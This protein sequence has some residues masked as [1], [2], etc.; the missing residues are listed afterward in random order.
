MIRDFI[1][2][3][4]ILFIV[5]GLCCFS[6]RPNG[7]SQ[8]LSDQLH[9]E[10]RE[11]YGFILS[12]HKH[13]RYIAEGHFFM[14]ELSAFKETDGQHDWE[15]IYNFPDIGFSF[16]ATNL[17]HSTYIGNA[18]GLFPFLN[19]P[20]TKKNNFSQSLRVGF[21][22]G[23]IEKP[24]DV[25]TNY[26]NIML[27]SRIN[28]CTN[29]LYQISW[30]INRFKVSG[31]LSFTHFSNGSVKKPNKGINIPTAHVGLAYCLDQELQQTKRREKKKL[32][33]SARYTIDLILM[34]GIHDAY[35]TETSHFYTWNISGDIS[36]QISEKSKLGAG[37][38]LFYNGAH[39]EADS[40]TS[41]T[42]SYMKPG[43]HIGHELIIARL[44]FIIQMGVYLYGKDMTEGIAYHRLAWRYSL[45]DH[46]K[47]GLNL[48]S[49][50]AK[51]ECLE[52]GIGYTI[53]K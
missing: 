27:G 12:H 51:A 15:H 39:K 41:N 42:L 36:R 31:G 26:K 30:D 37:L 32:S 24:F 1:N 23:L 25:R 17:G 8:T 53:L 9:F 7:Y 5:L 28:N 18:S 19:F 4:T 49:H 20:L 11:H 45:S 52:F 35:L 2:K 44:S 40:N 46:I 21:G 34:N 33:D 14:Q 50:Y 6:Y 29:L 43:I 10:S 13:T 3:K 47:I 16:I 38:D 22:I 48:K